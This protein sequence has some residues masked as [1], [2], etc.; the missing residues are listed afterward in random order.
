MVDEHWPTLDEIEAEDAGRIDEAR[1]AGHRERMRAE[2]R[3]YQLADIRKARG[4][5]QNEV[6]E[7][8]L[9]SQRRVSA[10]ERG[11]LPRTE[12]GTV[13]SY[14]QAL[15]GRIEIVANFGDRRL[16]IELRAQRGG[17]GYRRARPCRRVTRNA[18]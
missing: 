11:H 5:T 17:G 9:V 14:V 8:M 15:G 1:V 4:L 12:I 2:R 7:A 16:V 13:A 18:R 10:V 3:A 6:A